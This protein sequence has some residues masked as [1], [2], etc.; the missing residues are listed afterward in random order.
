MKHI[1]DPA[2]GN[3]YPLLSLK[4]LSIYQ[5]ISEQVQSLLQQ[6]G[7]DSLPETS[8]SASKE[9]LTIEE[10]IES[11]KQ[12]KQ[13]LEENTLTLSEEIDKIAEEASQENIKKEIEQKKKKQ[14]MSQKQRE[15]EA[16]RQEAEK[17]EG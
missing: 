3:Q 9:P 13:L 6:G 10:L 1:V 12:D 17:E 5:K 11:E 7:M 14:K 8:N 15:R 2:S 4:G 16:K